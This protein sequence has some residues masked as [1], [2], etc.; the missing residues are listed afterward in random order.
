MNVLGRLNR[1]LAI[2]LA[3]GVV[4]I[5][6]GSLL[7]YRQL[8]HGALE[9][10]P[11]KGSVIEVNDLL[12]LTKQ[13]QTTPVGGDPGKST[14]EYISRLKAIQKTCQRLNQYG[15]KAENLKITDTEQS[16]L[17]QTDALCTD[18]TKLSNYSLTIY[19]AIE[20]LMKAR[21]HTRR[22]ETFSP[23]A[24]HLKQSHLAATKYATAQLK[25]LP[26]DEVDFPTA[27]LKELA[28]LQSSIE[29]SQGLGYLATLQSFQL[30]MQG[31]RAQFWGPY[32]GTPQL[33]KSLE[34]QLIGYCQAVDNTSMSQCKENGS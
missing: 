19:G 4:I 12:A 17:N 11:I 18:V 30:A 28:K 2:V 21:T 10:N 13:L 27:S 26:T 9:K 22:Y 7:M 24:K 14:T 3:L 8:A 29:S 31:E 15:E 23:L 5:G 6:I 20:P 1:R 32:A 34:S 25:H 33:V 16:L